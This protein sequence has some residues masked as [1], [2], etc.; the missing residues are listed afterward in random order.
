MNINFS[1]LLSGYAY[2]RGQYQ[3]LNYLTTFF[4]DTNH[5]NK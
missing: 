4:E 2:P 1:K 5:D 3:F